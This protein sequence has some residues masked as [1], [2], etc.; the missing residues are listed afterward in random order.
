MPGLIEAAAVIDSTLSGLALLGV[1]Y[2][3]AVPLDEGFRSLDEQLATLPQSLRDNAATIGELVPQ[4]EGFR[5]QAVLL[6]GQVDK[7]SE[8]VSEARTVIQQ[9]RSTTDQL[10]LVIRDATSGLART[11]L[12]ARV[13]VLLMA[14]MVVLAMGGLLIVGRALSELEGPAPLV[15]V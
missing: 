8:T 14:V 3:P 1:P 4:A 15:E 9:Y 12:M 11:E 10:D 2:N 13:L 5:Q 6:A 7:M